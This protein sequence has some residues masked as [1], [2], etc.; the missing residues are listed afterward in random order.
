MG[1][2]GQCEKKAVVKIQ[3]GESKDKRW[4]CLKHYNLYMEANTEH[5]V[6]FQKASTIK[7]VGKDNI[8]L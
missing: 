2:C 3:L 4:L 7:S 1:R 6:V 8:L 5:K